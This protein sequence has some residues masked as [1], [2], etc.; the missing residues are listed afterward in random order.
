M[1][2]VRKN[3]ISKNGVPKKSLD[4]ALTCHKGMNFL[5]NV[6]LRS[7]NVSVRNGAIGLLAWKTTRNSFNFLGIS[8][9]NRSLNGTKQSF[10]AFHK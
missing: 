7:S 5:I 8:L 9:K 10:T 4:T 6:L 2:L 3:T 1:V